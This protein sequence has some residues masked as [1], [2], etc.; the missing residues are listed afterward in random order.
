MTLDYDDLIG[1]PFT[2]VGEQDCYALVRGF[3]K[4]NF[5]IDMEDFVRPN[6]WNSDDLNLIED[7]YERTG[8]EKIPNWKPKDLR[9]GDILA[10]AI[11]ERNPNHL[12]VYVGDSA[13]IHHLYGRLSSKVELRDFWFN[14]TCFLLR[15]P[16][17][18][19][20]RPVYPDVDILDIIRD[21]NTA[22]PN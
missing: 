19:D 17:V 4:T 10:M 18:P 13:I 6:D 1:K 14:S 3:F 12:A 5:D 2:G 20:L 21:R 9:P 8:F 16:A 11:G 15:H 7:L 22:P